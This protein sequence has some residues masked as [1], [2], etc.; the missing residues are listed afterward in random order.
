MRRNQG[1]L[2]DRPKGQKNVEPGGPIGKLPAAL[3]GDEDAKRAWHQALHDWKDVLG[4]AD[5]RLIEEYART[6]S[7]REILIDRLEGNPKDGEKRFADLK[8]SQLSSLLSNCER[9]I[10]RIALE[11]Q[12][13]VSAAGKGKP[14]RTGAESDRP[15]Q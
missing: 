12:R 3:Y 15:W 9:R 5:R 11:M 13:R 14:P 8:P 4:L 10:D 1:P 6:I 2:R 7:R